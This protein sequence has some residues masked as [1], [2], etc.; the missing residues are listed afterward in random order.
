LLDAATRGATDGA[1]LVLD[2]TAI[3]VAFIA[4]VAFL[5]AI[6]SFLGGLG[7]I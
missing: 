1:R 2:I 6:I 7:P 3:V 5:N 4:T